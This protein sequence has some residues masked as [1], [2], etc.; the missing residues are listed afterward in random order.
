[1]A[2]RAELPISS[3]YPWAQTSGADQIDYFFKKLKGDVGR[4]DHAA[5]QNCGLSGIEETSERK[6]DSKFMRVLHGRAPKL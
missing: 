4:A 6:K 5:I 2:K 1:L 3:L